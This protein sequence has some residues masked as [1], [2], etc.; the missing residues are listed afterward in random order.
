MI[1]EK[2]LN[3]FECDFHCD[4]LTMEK[5]E[6][7]KDENETTAKQKHYIKNNCKFP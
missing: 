7:V 4:C 6:S 5:P 2:I 3:I 1:K